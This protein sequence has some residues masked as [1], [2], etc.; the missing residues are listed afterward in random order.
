MI[1]EFPELSETELD[2]KTALADSTFHSWRRKSLQ[3]RAEVFRHMGVYL[4]RNSE[5]LATLITSEMGKPLKEAKSE[6]EKCASTAMYFSD[7]AEGMLKSQFVGTES[8][9]SYITFQP[10]GVIF[11]IMPWNYPFWQVFRFAIPTLMAGNTVV[12]KHSPNTWGSGEKIEELFREI[13]CPEGVF[14]HLRI[15][16]P[17]AENLIADRRITGVSLTGSTRAGRR[18]GSLAGQNLKKCVLELG[19]SDPYIVLDDADIDLASKICVQGRMINGGQSCVAAKRWIVTNK[20]YEEFQ[21]KVLELLKTKV[22]GDPTNP[23]TDLGPMARLDLRDQLHNQVLKSTSQ[24]SRLLLGGEVPKLPGFFYPTSLLVDVKPDQAAFQ[25]EIFGPVGVLIRARD[26]DEAIQLA[27]QTEYGLGGAIFSKDLERAE[28]LAREEVFSGQVFVNDFVKSDARM[29]FGGV[30]DS[31]LGRE[32]SQF[33]IREFT[34]VK[35][36]VVN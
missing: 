21:G 17:A 31:G 14:Q 29:P 9:K 34:N 15:D 4:K 2:T 10:T 1:S 7:Q 23:K 35:T 32:L 19:G 26:E 13:G 18:I 12:V 20:N 22:M 3:E 30:K 11:G 33:G 24:G 28:V 27:N 16:I 5:S 8:K 25:Q 36:I 6:V